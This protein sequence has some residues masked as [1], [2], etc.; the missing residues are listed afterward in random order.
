MSGTAWKSHTLAPSGLLIAEYMR[1][2]LILWAKN[3][4]EGK[5]LQADVPAVSALEGRINGLNTAQVLERFKWAAWGAVRPSVR[6]KTGRPPQHLRKLEALTDLRH[7]VL[8]ADRRAAGLRGLVPFFAP[9]TAKA[10]REAQRFCEAEQFEDRLR[11]LAPAYLDEDLPNGWDKTYLEVLER[12]RVASRK[13]E[14]GT[15]NEAWRNGI[16]RDL[17]TYALLLK[18]MATARRVMRMVK[19]NARTRAEAVI[20]HILENLERRRAHLTRRVK[21]VPRRHGV[22][23]PLHSRPRP[24]SAPLAPPCDLSDGA[25]LTLKA[26]MSR[27]QHGP[28]NRRA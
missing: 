22:R 15:M 27:R 11:D 26:C 18:D 3:P 5:W 23:R 12:F 16:L 24:P 7:A 8:I 2:P 17:L 21:P 9:K 25:R 1:G 19:H 10:R 6:W 28:D 14:I 4:R 13:Y 20:A